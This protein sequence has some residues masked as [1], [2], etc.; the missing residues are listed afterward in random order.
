MPTKKLTA[1]NFIRHEAT[2]GLLLVCAAIAAMAMENSSAAWLYDQILETKINLSIAQFAIN[3][4]FLLWVNDGLMAIFFFLVGLEIKRE[5]MVGELSSFRRASLPAV[6]A[7]GG[8]AIP[9]LAYVAINQ[10]NP[11]AMPGWAIPTATDIAFALGV[12]ALLGN[13]VPVV[14][15]IF[16]LAL[17][18][19]DDLGAIL[20]IAIFYTSQLSVYALAAAGV[21]V[22][23]LIALNQLRVAST[24]PYILI[25]MVIW[26]CVLKSGIHATLAGV[27]TALAIPLRA[28]ADQPTKDGPLEKL[29]HGLHPWIKFLVLPLFAFCNA[30]VS[31]AG[32]TLD[33]LFNPIPLGII[34]G[35]FVGKPVGI[36]LFTWFAVKTGIADKPEGTNWAQILGIAWLAGIGF[37]MS[38][39]IGMLAFPDPQY[40]A[41]IRL[42]VLTGSILSAFAGFIILLLSSAPPEPEA[43]QTT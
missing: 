27:I 43:A 36:F 33:S 32:I 39:F 24:A 29:E 15:K 9:A 40:A 4:P 20:I 42:G 25:G 11:V 41:D 7:L 35:L 19:I 8:I 16:L 28:F 14:L 12:V 5:L 30:G 22:V 10:D 23:A 34:A 18:I 31:L 1:L 2:G 38:L 6:G 17:A 26:V 37:T 13:R 3:K 21:G